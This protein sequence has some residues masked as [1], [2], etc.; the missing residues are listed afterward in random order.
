MPA[1]PKPADTAPAKRLLAVP[2]LPGGP[3]GDLRAGEGWVYSV[4]HNGDDFLKKN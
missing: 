3:H 4:I 2:D 1:D